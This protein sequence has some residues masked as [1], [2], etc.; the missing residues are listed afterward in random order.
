MLDPHPNHPIPSHPIPSRPIP[1]HPIPW[2]VTHSKV[3]GGVN[4]PHLGPIDIRSR[5]K[6]CDEGGVFFSQESP[7]PKIG[8]RLKTK[9]L[10]GGWFGLI[11]WLVGWLV[12]WVVLF[13]L[14]LFGLYFFQGPWIF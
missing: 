1:S 5:C 8:Q 12:G 14:F 13:F 3:E 9:K 10:N 7:P 4:D 6:T 11:G 2:P